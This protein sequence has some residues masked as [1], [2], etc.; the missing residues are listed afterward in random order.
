MIALLGE[1]CDLTG[2]RPA[3]WRLP[4]D[5]ML[6][7]VRAGEQRLKHGGVYVLYN[8]ENPSAAEELP[9]K[10]STHPFRFC[11]QVPDRSSIGVSLI[12]FL[13]WL[14]FLFPA[15]FDFFHCLWNSIKNTAKKVGRYS[16]RPRGYLWR[17]ILNFVCIANMNGG[18]YRSGQWVELKKS[19]ARRFHDMYTYASEEFQAIAGRFAKAAGHDISTQAGIEALFDR[20]KSLKSCSEVGQR[21]KLMRFLSIEEQWVYHKDEIFG[22]KAVLKQ[23]SVDAAAG[24]TGITE[25]AGTTRGGGGRRC[26]KGPHIQH[27]DR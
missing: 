17:Y 14:G 25:H 12:H 24:H 21:V 18:P 23:M 22:L 1:L 6:R 3:D 16:G 5:I 10:Y 4:N 8:T 20:M 27:G 19:A 13:L 11:T 2:T 9:A 7:P 15:Y 26:P